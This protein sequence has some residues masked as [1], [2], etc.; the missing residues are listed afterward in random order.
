M[1][2]QKSV[3]LS[4]SKC[5]VHRL[6]ANYID[7]CAGLHHYCVNSIVLSADCEESR[8]ERPLIL[9]PCYNRGE[10][11]LFVHEGGIQNTTFTAASDCQSK[12]CFPSHMLVSTIMKQHWD[13]SKT[14]VFTK[15]SFQQE[16]RVEGV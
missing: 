16:V 10:I 5:A 14:C 3:S 9:W 12:A 15:Y 6:S 11:E 8:C 13:I 7:V 1:I 4:V 2:T